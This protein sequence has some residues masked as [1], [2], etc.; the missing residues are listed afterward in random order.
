V[1]V[2]NEPAIPKQ[3]HLIQ[4]KNMSE[5]QSG[6]RREINLLD[7]IM[8]VAGTMIGSGI[9][10]VSADI[11][12]NVGSAGWLLAVWAVSG[13]IT[14]L[15]AMA[16][17]ELTGMFPKAGGQYVFLREAYNP[18][19]AFLYGWTLFL[20]IQTGTIAAVGVAFAK[21]TGV[22]I[23]AFDQHHPGFVLF[24][25]A[26]LKI[27]TQQ[28]LAIAIIAFL[29]M[30]NLN[31][32]RAG[33]LIQTA[34]GSSKI[35]ALLAL[36]VMGLF[37]AGSAEI[38]E[39]N[40]S[41]PWAA[42]RITEVNG[43]F[44]RESL[45]G[46]SLLIALG[47]ASVGSLFAM[48]AWNNITF[49]GDEVVNPKRT[50][51]LSMFIG[52]ALVVVIYLLLNLIYVLALP[53]RGIPDGVNEISRG[54]QFASNDRVGVAVAD[55]LS[56]HQAVM[57][58]AALI[59]VSTFSCLNG[60]ILSGARVYFKMAEDN[61]F[62]SGMKRLNQNGVPSLA[63]IMQAVWASALCLSGTYGNLLDYVV[64]AVLLFYIF[65]IAGIFILRKKMPDI[66]R[67]YKT[68]AYP[69]SPVIYLL[70]ASAICIILLLYKQEYTFPGLAIVALGIPAFYVFRKFQKRK[71]Q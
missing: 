34:L 40:F 63:L 19:F 13:F 25:I 36:I 14:I 65:T 6:F 62:F 41:N 45:T 11:A 60:L 21:F 48:D 8:L 50:I 47:I 15:G 26:G 29:T 64:F 58:I 70:L 20:V 55:I 38:W 37:A 42:E 68:F 27:N 66:P 10:I 53:V 52:V 61:L 71:T 67:P 23:P 56:G 5:T 17:G 24:Q 59:M 32:V 43:T 9:F 57:I 54:I 39:M 16:Y 51:P 2:E 35:L 44:E 7:G 30:M 3:L 1:K 31:G 18:L 28:I 33:K 4:T 22:F 49:A 69:F 12:R 46:I